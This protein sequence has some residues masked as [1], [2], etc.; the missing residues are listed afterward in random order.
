ML[1]SILVY[2]FSIVRSRKNIYCMH[3]NITLI[4]VVAKLWWSKSKKCVRLIDITRYSKTFI[5]WY[6]LIL[7]HA[8]MSD[9]E[10]SPISSTKVLLSLIYSNFVERTVIFLGV[11]HPYCKFSTYLFSIIYT[12]VKVIYLKSGEIT[13]TCSYRFIFNNK[14]IVTF[15]TKYLFYY[16]RYYTKFLTLS[17]STPFVIY[18]VER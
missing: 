13:H 7:S 5:Y 11:D 2:L 12:F 15:S 9:C 3:Y 17:F 14:K 6:G 10:W 16:F 18:M 4:T 8:F 1:V